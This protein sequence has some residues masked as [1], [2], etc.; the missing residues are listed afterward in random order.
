M[1]HDACCK[2][3]PADRWGNFTTQILVTFKLPVFILSTTKS[4]DNLRI[5]PE[6]WSKTVLGEDNLEI[7]FRDW[8]VWCRNVQRLKG[9]HAYP[10]ESQNSVS[11]CACAAKT[12]PWCYQALNTKRFYT[13]MPTAWIFFGFVQVNLFWLEQGY[14]GPGIAITHVL[15]TPC[16]VH[17]YVFKS[18]SFFGQHNC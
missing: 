16:I 5:S 8:R 11:P 12:L 10:F 1:C 6:P 7:R 4:S 13:G 2:R 15:F 14:G 18:N 3:A 17:S 9:E